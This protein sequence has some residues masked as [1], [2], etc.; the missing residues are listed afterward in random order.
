[1]SGQNDARSA[2]ELARQ[3]QALAERRRQHI[4]ELHR[5][6]R[7]RRYYTEEQFTAQM[8]D[9]VRNIEAW[10]AAE[11]SSAADEAAPAQEAAE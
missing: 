3:W 10:G 8:R 7:W 9:A 5:T 6:G 4:L 1:M 2:Q 11:K